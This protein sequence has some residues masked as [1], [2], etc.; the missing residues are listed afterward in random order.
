MGW[1]GLL[2]SPHSH[3]RQGHFFTFYF[4]LYRAL[5]KRQQNGFVYV[6]FTL[7]V[8]HHSRQPSASDAFLDFVC[9]VS[10]QVSLHGRTLQEVSAFL[11]PSWLLKLHTQLIRVPSSL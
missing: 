4:T 5:R 3:F 9:D 6:P 8:R 10:Q 2:P 11:E 1:T 7:L